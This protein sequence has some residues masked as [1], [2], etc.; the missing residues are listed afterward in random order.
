MFQT[1]PFY[2]DRFLEAMLIASQKAQIDLDRQ[3]VCCS[4]PDESC[5]DQGE[6]PPGFYKSL[7]N[8]YELTIIAIKLYDILVEIKSPL[9]NFLHFAVG[10]TGDWELLA[11]SLNQ[12]LLTS[13]CELGKEW[14]DGSI[15]GS[16]PIPHFSAITSTYGDLLLSYLIYLFSDKTSSA[17]LF[18]Q[19]QQAYVQ[20]STEC[21][22]NAKYWDS[23]NFNPRKPF[24]YTNCLNIWSQ[25][26][27]PLDSTKK[28]LDQPY[29]LSFIPQ[30]IW[31]AF[32][33]DFLRFLDPDHVIT[34][35]T[36]RVMR[37]GIKLLD[38]RKLIV[39][40]C[41]SMIIKLRNS[42]KELYGTDLDNGENLDNIFDNPEIPVLLKVD[43]KNKI[44]NF[45]INLI[46]NW[47][48]LNGKNIS[49]IS[50]SQLLERIQTILENGITP[51]SLSRD[52]LHQASLLMNKIILDLTI[53]QLD[54]PLFIDICQFYNE[55]CGLV[56]NNEI[57]KN[58][59][60][61]SNLICN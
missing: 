6:L 28:E 57:L 26:D 9:L 7:K 17:F 11:E 43:D 32:I 3:T 42:Y 55:T 13:A 40:T 27:L 52:I 8:K 25:T 41:E 49:D 31:Q 51:L 16:E 46:V 60:L 47:L 53:N 38:N 54:E 29:P 30:M 59:V 18:G 61:L 5:S 19:L 12:T 58:S 35:D 2:T 34:H 14:R 10:L 36:R 50:I 20:S 1:S 39:Q 37:R 23:N 56:I 33:L 21:I 15:L 44:L 4:Q 24:S 48:N 45:F 22:N